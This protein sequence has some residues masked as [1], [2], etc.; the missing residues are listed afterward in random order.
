MRKRTG[1]IL[2]GVVLLLIIVTGVYAGIG[3]Y[4]QTH[5]FEYTTINGID[6]SDLTAEEAESLIRT[7]AEDYTLTV[8]TKEGTEEQIRGDAIGYRF[9][10]KGE[11]QGFLDGQAYLAWLPKY[12]GGPNL[13]TMTASVTYDETL[14]TEAA[15]GLACMQADQVTPP[16]DAHLEQQNGQYV[17]VPEVEGNQLD[18]AKVEQTLRT[19]VEAGETQVDLQEKNCYL[20]PQVRAEDGEL[21]AEAAVRNKYS[22]LTVTYNLGGGVQEILDAATIAA[23][24]S[25]DENKQPVFDRSAVGAWVNQLADNYDT[26]GKS[27][28]FVTS[29]GETVY[30]EARTYGWQMDRESETEALYQML[31]AGESGE[32]SPVWYEGAASRGQ[33]DIGNTYVEIDYTNQR[34]WYYKDGVLLVETPVV[35]G[36]VSAG[37]ASP[38]GIF[39][40]V[41]KSE[42]ETLK[43]EGYSTPVEYW[44]PFYGGVGIHDADTWRDTYGGDIYQWGGSHGCINTPTAQVAVIYQ[45]I[46]IGT[47][48]VCYSSGI[49]YGYQQVSGGGAAN[50]GSGAAGNGAAN[51]GDGSGAAGNGAANGGDGSGAAGNGA[52]NSGGSGDIVI[53][54]GGSDNG[55]NGGNGAGGTS[56]GVTQGVTDNG[57]PY[58]GEDLQDVEILGESTFDIP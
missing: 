15:A 5:F 1:I 24:F 34:L 22:S 27:E 56:G 11:V 58:T 13:Y 42:D 14:L 25:L 30:V 49:N 41:G 28:P 19:A 10:S 45:N 43:G 12:F 7:E 55:G 33:N 32:R 8:R 39:C 51:G 46:E 48:I 20:L 47:P 37:H 26:I 44:M 17:I 36:N 29:N 2:A 18:G 9:V 6:V 57:V 3:L 31:C 38:E 35:T 40:L 50:G 16:A 54:D 4:Y 21:K 53:L 23:W 52:V